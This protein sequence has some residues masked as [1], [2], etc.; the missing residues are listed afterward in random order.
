MRASRPASP[1]CPSPD[2]ARPTRC[3]RPAQ[4]P[5]RRVISPDVTALHTGL[6]QRVRVD[7]LDDSAI[8]ALE[9]LIDRDPFVNAGVA[10]RVRAARSLDPQR[11]GGTMVG[12]WQ[13]DE[14]TGACYSGGNLV[15]VGGDAVSWE[16][17][18]RFVARRP[19]RCTSIV[20]RA[21]SVE[22]L[23]SLLTRSWTAA[24]SVRANQPLLMLDRPVLM[25]GDDRVRR[26]RPAELERY[27]PAAAA[28]FAEELGVSPHVAPGSAAFGVRLRELISTG[29][30]F[31]SFDFRGQVTF[32][33]E[34]GAVSGHTCQIQ[35]VWVRPDLRGQ[36]LGTASLA[37][38]MTH[39]L[40]VAPT[41]SLYVNDFNTAAR[42]MYARLGMR[43]VSTL[44]TVLL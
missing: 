15:P 21:D 22:V 25:R 17:I 24:R 27:L 10:A 11:L 33:A 19:R 14:L 42:R 8:D 20:G 35:G 5:R 2:T 4:R 38:V 40:A 1:P 30:A 36:G 43:Q 39:A 18:A 13:G 31:A 23:W 44:S 7:V 34:I 6:R 12:V 37:T 9:S 3:S 28:M 32:K 26:A 29:R 41:A 16:R